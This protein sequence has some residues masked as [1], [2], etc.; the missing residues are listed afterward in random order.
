VVLFVFA[1][2]LPRFVDIF[3]GEMGV[4]VGVNF[5]HADL[6]TEDVEAVGIGQAGGE[7]LAARFYFAAH[8]VHL[9][10]GVLA[11]EHG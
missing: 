2:G 3:S 6:F 9:R 11:A 10:G 5:I 7:L 8:D 1:A 4:W